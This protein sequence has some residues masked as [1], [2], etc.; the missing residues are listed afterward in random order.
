MAETSCGSKALQ[1][2][3]GCPRIVY[4]AGHFLFDLAAHT[5]VSLGALAVFLAA[6][7]TTVGGSAAAAFGTF[8]LLELFGAAAIPWAYVQSLA[9]TC[10]GSGASRGG[11]GS[12]SSAQVA[13]TAVNLGTGF[14]LVAA[15]TLLSTVPS[16]ANIARLGGDAGRMLFP[17]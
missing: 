11:S 1:L 14:L 4:W 3:A 8:L 16:A 7:S 9:T 5:V 13:V 10:R 15:V 2:S 12:P 6:G 17:P